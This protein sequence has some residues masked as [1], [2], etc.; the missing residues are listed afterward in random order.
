MTNVGR[1]R[2]QIQRQINVL[3]DH[4]AVLERFPDRDPYEDDTVVRFRLRWGEMTYT[5][6]AV[7]ATGRWF[8]TA[9]AAGHKTHRSWLDFVDWMTEAAEIVSFEVMTVISDELNPQRPGWVTDE[10]ACPVRLACE[11]HEAHLWQ[12]ADAPGALANSVPPTSWCP[13]YRFARAATDPSAGSGL[14]DPNQGTD[15]INPDDVP[16]EKSLDDRAKAARTW[17][18]RAGE[19]V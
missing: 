8:T 7:R 9:T 15:V 19:A 13:G 6:A 16:P 2:A 12:R 18:R 1:R 17:I 14:P 10:R 4:A 11:E 5:Y 3:L